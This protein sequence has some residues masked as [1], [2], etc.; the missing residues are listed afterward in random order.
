[1]WFE[2]TLSQTRFRKSLIMSDHRPVTVLIVESTVGRTV[3]TVTI[4]E[5]FRTSCGGRV[6][7]SMVGRRGPRNAT[8]SSSRLA[9]LHIVTTLPTCLPTL[10]LPCIAP[11][12]PLFTSLWR[13]RVSRPDSGVVSGC[14]LM[15]DFVAGGSTGA[16][17]AA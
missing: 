8:D 15:P 11:N 10:V 17:V 2:F 5:Y 13:K 14:S 1:M 3:A 16:P 9:A 12:C 7:R 4:Y 6:L